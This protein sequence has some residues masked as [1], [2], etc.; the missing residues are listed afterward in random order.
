MRDFAT[1][2]SV[3]DL[4]LWINIYAF[5]V[6]GELFYGNMFGFMRERKDI[7]GYMNA[8]DALLPAFSIGGTVPSYLTKPFLIS[9]TLFSPSIRGALG[10]VKHLE[11]ASQAAVTKR[12]DQITNNKDE[13]RDMLR[14]M[15]DI[16]AERGTELDFTDSHVFVESHSSFFAGADTTAIA[17]NSILYHLMRNPTAYSKLTAEVDAA[18][19]DGTLSMPITYREAVKL[20]YLNACVNEGMRLHPSV[21]LHMPRIVPPGGATISGFHFPAGYR[22]GIN[23]ATV[24]YDE[25]IFGSD[26]YSFNPDRWIKGDALRME[27]AIIVFGTGPRTCIGKNISLSEI[28]KL[29]PQ[30]V[31]DFEIRLVEPEK[32]WKTTDYWFHKQTGIN[33]YV[34]ERDHGND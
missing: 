10:A 28:Y 18:I 12:K 25:E 11:K 26:A 15:L 5:D 24:Q 2:N 4:G 14:K 22:I 29:V 8:I 7:S 32:G 27:R 13:K 9:T 23:A 34:R 31:R 19:S 3:V 6:L 17:I 30:I 20:S 16:S 1:Q 33:V 21:G